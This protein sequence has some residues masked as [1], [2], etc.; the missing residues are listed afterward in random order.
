MIPLGHCDRAVL[1]FC[2]PFE[3][4]YVQS[5]IIICEQSIMW[6]VSGILWYCHL[7]FLPSNFFLFAL[8]MTR[9]WFLHT[10]KSYLQDGNVCICYAE[11]LNADRSAGSSLSAVYFKASA[12]DIVGGWGLEKEL[13][14][15]MGRILSAGR[16]SGL[17]GIWSGGMFMP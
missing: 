10:K 4:S 14:G 8:C 1:E 13:D 17:G 6:K 11:I 16:T 12:L 5:Y 3:G 2:G 9:V 15:N 7:D